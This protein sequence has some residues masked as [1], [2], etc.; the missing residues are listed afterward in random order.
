MQSLTP[1]HKCVDTGFI[2]CT[3]YNKLSRIRSSAIRESDHLRSKGVGRTEK[4]SLRHISQKHIN[5]P[6]QSPKKTVFGSF[7]ATR[8]V[9]SRYMEES[10]VS[11]PAGRGRQ[12]EHADKLRTIQS[13]T[14]HGTHESYVGLRESGSDRL[15]SEVRQGRVVV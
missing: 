13:A 12:W 4:V 9:H 11:Q 5:R 1:S 10:R 8:T 6:G 14:K 3:C 15:K 2:W 7:N